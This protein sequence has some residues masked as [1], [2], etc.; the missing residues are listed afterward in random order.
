M[1]KLLFIVFY[2]L[3]SCDSSI[4]HVATSPTTI[5][6]EK[7]EIKIE[8][9]EMFIYVIDS[10]EYIGTIDGTESR[11]NFLTHKGNCK[12]CSKRK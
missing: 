9:Q 4:Q 11:S 5:K 1:K 12:F 7:K 2:L 10:C 6:I 8:K 3:I